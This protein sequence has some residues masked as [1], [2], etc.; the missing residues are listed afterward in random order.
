[1]SMNTQINSPAYCNCIPI[2]LYSSCVYLAIVPVSDKQT[3]SLW[4]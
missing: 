4:L 3:S 2:E 1:M